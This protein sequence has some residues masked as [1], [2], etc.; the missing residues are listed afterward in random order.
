MDKS[1]KAAK[2]T[3]SQKDNKRFQYAATVVLNHEEIKKD[4]QSITKIKSFVDKCNWEGISY[5][6]EKD[7]WKIFVKNNLIIFLD[8]AKLKIVWKK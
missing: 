1:K 5:P 6:T 3:V 7:D 8:S 2:N 4:P